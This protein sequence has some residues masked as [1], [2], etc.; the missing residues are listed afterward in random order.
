MDELIQVE[1]NL[2]QTPRMMQVAGMFD[3]TPAEHN[4]LEWQA[5]LP[6]EEKPWNVGLIVGPSGAGKTILAQRLFGGAI[7]AP[8]DW[9]PDGSVLDAFPAE[10]GIK[11]VVKALTAVGFSSPPAW[12]RPFRVLSNGEQFRAS[13]ALA[14]SRTDGLLVVDEFTSVVDRQVAKV[15]S[16]ALQKAVRRAKR[17]FVAV[18]CHYDVVDWLQPDW[19]Y[20]PTDGSFIWRCLQ[21][22]PDVELAIH[23]VN[24]T[25]WPVFS[26]H[27]YVSSVLATSAQC[28][29]A[30]WGDDCIAF[31][32][33]I[34]QPHPT[35]RNIKLGHRLVVLPDFQGMGIGVAFDEWLGQWLY[36]SGQRYHN[37]VSHP[38][39][40]A[41]YLRSS[42][43]RC[44]FKPS[45]RLPSGAGGVRARASLRSRQSRGR[46]ANTYGFEYVPPSGTVKIPGMARK[47][48]GS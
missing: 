22:H 18:T 13:M 1:S 27:H 14:L 11:D 9:D 34:H 8:C 48:T 16:H 42:R 7:L 28:F 35:Q 6:V 36:E 3:M 45:N 23:P 19:V 32:S 20:Q 10:L 21:R 33:Y 29:G 15:A 47:G 17:Q 31:N 12:L 4:H 25:I 24:R 26:H 37:V 38:A 2:P 41:G 5:H 39:I 43:W 46:R 30:F 44:Y 40:V